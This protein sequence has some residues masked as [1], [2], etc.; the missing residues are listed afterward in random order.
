MSKPSEK[1]EEEPAKRLSLKSEDKNPPEKN[2]TSE[3]PTEKAPKENETS[4]EPD[5]G[6]E[7]R[8]DSIKSTDTTILPTTD[9]DDDSD[10]ELIETIGARLMEKASEGETS[11]SEAEDQSLDEDEEGWSEAE[12]SEAVKSDTSIGRKGKFEKRDKHG[13]VDGGGKHCLAPYSSVVCYSLFICIMY[14]YRKSTIRY[15]PRM[16]SSQFKLDKVE[17]FF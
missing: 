5:T 17:T 14:V 12:S 11:A 8:T 7:Y 10:D 15:M 13:H 9:D 4:E 3:K 2:P 1:P 16:L 6:T